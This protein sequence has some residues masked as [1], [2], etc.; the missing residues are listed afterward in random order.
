MCMTPS[1]HPIALRQRPPVC[2][3]SAYLIKRHTQWLAQR[4]IEERMVARAHRH[5]PLTDVQKVQNRLWAGTRC[6][7]ARTFGLVLLGY[8]IKRGLNLRRESVASIRLLRMTC[9]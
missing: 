2:A 1:L 7:V 6:T 8:N 5:K 4:D 3:D 9:L